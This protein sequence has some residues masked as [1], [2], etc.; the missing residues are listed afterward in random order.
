MKAPW[1]PARFK[2]PRSK[3][4]HQPQKA[5][6]TEKRRSSCHGLELGYY[7]RAYSPDC[8]SDG[9]HHHVQV[10]LAQMESSTTAAS[11]IVVRGGVRGARIVKCVSINVA[12]DVVTRQYMGR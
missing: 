4:A 6:H 3:Q 9:I 1:R 12:V 2:M 7:Q 11:V 5:L 10:L 8:L